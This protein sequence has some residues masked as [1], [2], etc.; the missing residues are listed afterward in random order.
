MDT[1]GEASRP[2]ETCRCSLF[3]FKSA[4]APFLRTRSVRIHTNHL[5]SIFAVACAVRAQTPAPDY[6]KQ[7]VTGA[8]V[9]EVQAGPNSGVSYPLLNA[10]PG[11]GIDYGFRP[12]RW[13]MLEAGFEQ[14]VRPVGSSVCCEYSTNAEDQLYLVPFGARFVWEPRSSRARLTAGGGAAYLN[15]NV[16][17]LNGGT[18]GFSGWGGQFVA[19][20][21][22]AVTRSG[23]L[24]VGLTAR[25]YVGAPKP[26]ADY[27]PPGY[28]PSDHLRILVIGPAVTFSF[29]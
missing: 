15:H 26:S 25:Y 16:G 10:A 21:D 27:G 5:I 19:S 12:R 17:N 1:P 28:N 6:F 20:G 9:Y 18:V 11:Y 4:S 14:I 7:S 3:P 22:Y 2:K 13:L 29:R 8:F 23:R 24:R